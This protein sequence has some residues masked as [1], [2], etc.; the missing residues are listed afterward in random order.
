MTK[1]IFSK[2]AKYREKQKTAFTAIT[3]TYTTDLQPNE[4]NPTLKMRLHHFN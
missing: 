3:T 4:V 1:G 2:Q